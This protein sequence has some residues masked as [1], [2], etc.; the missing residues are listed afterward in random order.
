[1]EWYI[2]AVSSRP[3]RGR[4]ARQTGQ[5]TNR[6]SITSCRLHGGSYVIAPACR[7]R[8]RYRGGICFRRIQSLRHVTYRRGVDFGRRGHGR[9]GAARAPHSA[10][11]RNAS[12]ASGVVGETSRSCRFTYLIASSARAG[13]RADWRSRGNVFA[14]KDCPTV[15]G[16]TSRCGYRTHSPPALTNGRSDSRTTTATTPS[17]N[18]QR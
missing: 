1:M 3:E 5:L 16:V 15:P 6:R 10:S 7:S 17:N 11:F 12:G 4:L 14:V 9:D 18:T 13:A 8:R 2:A